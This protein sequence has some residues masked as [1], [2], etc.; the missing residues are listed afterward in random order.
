ML[1]TTFINLIKFT[2]YNVI[3]K[4]TVIL[5]GGIIDAVSFR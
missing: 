3:I 1:F 2:S 5:D 4:P